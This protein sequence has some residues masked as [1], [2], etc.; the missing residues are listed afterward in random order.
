M[1]RLFPWKSA[2]KLPV[3]ALVRLSWPTIAFYPV[4]LRVNSRYSGLATVGDFPAIDHHDCNCRV[5]PLRLDGGRRDILP[6]AAEGGPR[7]FLAQ[8]RGHLW[9]IYSAFIR[10][11]VGIYS[12]FIRH[13][14]RRGRI[15]G[16]RGVRP[17]RLDGGRRDILPI[18]GQGGPRPFLA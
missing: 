14:V 5:R 12:A 6:S 3:P 15:A 7:P 18:G 11:L 16:G 4:Y 17:L 13:L 8:F 10:H 2:S 9:A 1:P